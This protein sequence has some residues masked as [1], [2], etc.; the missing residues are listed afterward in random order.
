M[1]DYH[2]LP[3][4]RFDAIARGTAGPETIQLLLKTEYSRRLLLL[5]KLLDRATERPALLHGLPSAEAAWQAL[6]RMAAC[7]SEVVRRILL[8]PQVGT[9]I[10]HAL[11]QSAGEGDRGIPDWAVVGQI[12]AVILAA[13]IGTGY[14]LRTRVPVRRGGVL[15]PTLGLARFPSVRGY[16]VAEA[17]TSAGTCRLRVADREVEVPARPDVDGEDWWS[18]RSRSA[19][20]T[21]TVSLDDIDPYRNLA[22]PIAPTRLDDHV[23][24]DWQ[25]L[26]DEAWSILSDRHSSVADAMAAGLQSIAPLPDD[27]SWT[28]RSASTGDGFG[29]VLTST[30]PDAATLAVT[31][32]HEFQHIVLGGLLQLVTL[33]GEDNREYL[34]APWR[35]DPRPLAGFLQGVYAFFG[36]TRFWRTE[37]HGKSEHDRATAGFEFAY[38]RRQTWAGLRALTG[39]PILTPL[40]GRFIEQVTAEVRPWLREG[41][42]PDLAEAAWAA[43]A[44]HRAGWRIRNRTVDRD[45]VDRAAVAWRKRSAPPPTASASSVDAGNRPVWVPGRLTL[46]RAGLGQRKDLKP[47]DVPDVTEADHALVRRDPA[48]AGREY[49]RRIRADHGDLDAWTGLGLAGAMTGAPA[50]RPLLYRP[51]LVLALYGELARRSGPPAPAPAPE[52][53]AE[54][55]NGRSRAVSVAGSA[56]SSREAPLSN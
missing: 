44:D 21:L 41:V 20:R 52:D 15:L 4:E 29:G 24:A 25:R 56:D 37:C 46:F 26:L 30:P 38:A 9:W 33:H 40:G 43:Y 27:P 18:L 32:V 36:I 39:S 55:M 12:H 23:L 3:L 35:P 7:S 51:E 10:S 53:L 49:A 6:D 2:R 54:W 1:V 17:S 45:W 13:A 22:D 31:L 16:A 48:A 50:W 42:R 14:P 47:L 11:R 5:R 28:I 34:Y 8:Q 19:G